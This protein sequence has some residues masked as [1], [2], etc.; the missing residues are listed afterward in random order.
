MPVKK[1]YGKYKRLVGSKQC[2][3]GTIH[4]WTSADT[5]HN[6]GKVCGTGVANKKKK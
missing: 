1:D 5:W 3:R 2:I 6:T 4:T